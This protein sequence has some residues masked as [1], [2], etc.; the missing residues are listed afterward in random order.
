MYLQF[1]PKHIYIDVYFFK[2]FKYNIFSQIFH[3]SCHLLHAFNW[4]KDLIC[5]NLQRYVT[6]V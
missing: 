2:Y 6:F 5:K 1:S 3:Q 4:L